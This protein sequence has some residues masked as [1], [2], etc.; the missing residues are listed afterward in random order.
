[1][2]TCE[3]C[4]V[5]NP[6]GAR[7]CVACGASLAPMCP[8]CGAE[9][10]GAAVRFCPSCGQPV[11][12]A[13][14]AGQERK[15]VTVLF[16]D[17]TGSTGLGERL[18]PERLREVMDAYFQAMREEIE[19]EGGTIEK[20]IGDAVM[21]AFGVPAAHEDDAAR[22]LRAAV[23]MQA[24]LEEVN[25]RL[26]R[27]H[28]VTLRIRIAVNTGEVLAATA[29][30]PGEALVT[31]D[32]V[33][34]A[35]RLQQAAEPGQVVASGRTA[36][37][38][39]RFRFRPLGLVELKGK[40]A[41]VE[42]LLLLGEGGTDERGVPGLHAPMVGRAEE[43]ALLE[44][45]FERTARE[46]RANL[47]TIY[48]EPG[49]GKSRLTAEFL[50][51]V[52]GRDEATVVLR[53]RCLPYGE[54]VTYW[55]LAEILK[56]FAGIL[57]TDPPDAVLDKIRKVGTELITPELAASPAKAVAAL[58]Y[59]VGVE[60]PII[61]W[62]ELDPR[63]VRR[64]A[65]AA[66]RSFFSALAARSPVVTVI[67]DIHWADP[68]LLGLLEEL[69]DR[70][71]GPLLFV[72]PA[73]P[74]LAGR[75][76]EWGGGRRNFS[77]VG[78]EPLSEEEADRLIRFLLTVEDLPESVHRRILE[79]AEGNPFFLEEIVRQLIDETRIVREAGRWRAAS[80][81]ENVVIPDSVQ[82]VLAARIDLLSPAEK[83]AIQAAAVVGRVF[84]LGP[85]RRLMDGQARELDATLA[86]L[87]DREFVLS[88]LGSSMAGEPEF[89]FKH[90][91]IRDVAYES[92]PRRERGAA[93]Q[94]VAQWI[95][96]T[97]G[98]R[99]R[100]F[101][102]LLAYHYGMAIQV[103]RE[104]PEVAAGTL[105]EL[106]AK[107]FTYL[108]EASRDARSKLVSRKALRL[109]EQALALAVDDLE[110]SLAIEAMGDACQDQYEGDL[111][112]TYFKDAADARRAAAPQDRARIAYL[113]ARACDVPCRWPGSMRTTASMEEVARYLDLGMSLV[114]EGD[115]EERVRLLSVRAFWPFAFPAAELTAEQIAMMRQS[116][117]E[118]AEMALRL[119]RSDL[120]SA[121]LDG[122]ASAYVAEGLY[123][124][125]V[126]TI[127]RRL[128]LVPE[129]EDPWEIGDIHGAAA[130]SRV[131]VGL[132]RQA[133]RFANDG[134]ERMI[135]D[136]PSV[137]LHCVAWRAA[138]RFRLG[139][140]TGLLAD[141]ELVRDMLGE[142]RDDPPYFTSRPFAAA[143]LVHDA[144]GNGAAADRL[145]AV[146]DRLWEGQPERAVFA[147]IWVAQALGRRGHFRAAWDMIEATTAARVHQGLVQ[148][149]RCE[150]VAEEGSWDRAAEILAEA[151]A[152]AT[153]GDLV[154][155]PLFA[156]RLE[157][158]AALAAGDA[159]LALQL[160][161]RASVGF[162]SLE[163]RWERAMTNLDLAEALLAA[164]EPGRA[165]LALDMALPVLEE[166]SSLRE[167]ER[168]RKLAKELD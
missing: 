16:A 64:K 51:R 67:E 86:R 109:G 73:R 7:F 8:H 153:R 63:E 99:Q 80:D 143:V 18:D 118:A 6:H 124:G 104:S 68:A 101:V 9:L 130:W 29:P 70:S 93:H 56:G 43:L 149:V 121:A 20:F 128:A 81:I 131:D 148:E 57:D 74:E 111:A 161:A 165:R 54:G 61:S 25:R 84:W 89:I 23:R 52:E 105:D 48:G 22:A 90:I 137:A 167:I 132:Y 168:A 58:A 92:L 17:V 33:N 76:P 1:M 152:V 13:A 78:L 36:R 15:L 95:E 103:A 4:G 69:A 162:G 126:R 60:D 157:G 72:C 11:R 156:D 120:A 41:P 100:E 141:L 19:A 122:A 123:G 26:E 28:D 146:L 163:A 136:V 133:L 125:A 21:A 14:A 10:P 154:A 46:G 27:S 75:R 98:E 3:A 47:V 66:W 116:G 62:T 96:E 151:R 117:E 135:R 12:E 145:L 77:S 140:W 35:S 88:R 50:A 38:A 59:T 127:D 102:E 45:V 94:A 44:A 37:A 91:L 134:Y 82:A 139:D 97:A 110:R 115:G 107:A 112:F 138:A 79:R 71:Q 142:R 158:R 39:R 155:L 53:G 55:P 159:G 24:R 129:L 30:H 40:T 65:H 87:E 85:V 114:P 5:E 166:L 108:L 119:G 160:L 31:G 34:V 150:L 147:Q 32:A 113:C 106:R 144:Q 83:R 42:A 49:V 2:K 164:G